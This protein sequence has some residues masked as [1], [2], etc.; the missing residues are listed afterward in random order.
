[1]R[2]IKQPTRDKLLRFHARGI[3]SAEERAVQAQILTYLETNRVFIA[4]FKTVETSHATGVVDESVGDL[5]T[6]GFTDILAFET[7]GAFVGVD[8]NREKCLIGEKSHGCSERAYRIA[9]IAAEE[10]RADKNEDK[11]DNSGEH[12]G[13]GADTEAYPC[14]LYRGGTDNRG[15]I[16]HDIPGL[17]EIGNDPKT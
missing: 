4:D 8:L 17:D 5:H 15:D 1:M 11:G 6:R 3:L 12:T 13:R 10:E 9:E 7:P 2:L 16:P 14:G